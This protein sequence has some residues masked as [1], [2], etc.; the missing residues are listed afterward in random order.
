MR[1]SAGTGPGTVA[2]EVLSLA[3][4]NP[5]NGMNRKEYIGPMAS[6]VEADSSLGPGDRDRESAGTGSVSGTENASGAGSGAA[7]RISNAIFDLLG[8]VP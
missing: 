2:A 7:N 6:A 3:P 4:D 1:R 8:Q 5:R